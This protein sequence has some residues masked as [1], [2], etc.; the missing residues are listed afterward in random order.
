[1]SHLVLKPQWP[2]QGHAEAM[3]QLERFGRDV[4]PLLP[5]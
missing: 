3:G 2:G 4:M 5:T 1:M